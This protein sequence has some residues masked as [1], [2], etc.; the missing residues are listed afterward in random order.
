MFPC[1]TIS[2]FHSFIS[3]NT[4]L[5]THF[6]NTG[7]QLYEINEERFE[8]VIPAQSFEKYQLDTASI[9]GGMY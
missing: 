9:E 5:N 8:V 6:F 4:E 1:S 3:L 2:K 7:T